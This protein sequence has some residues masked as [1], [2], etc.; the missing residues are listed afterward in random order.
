MELLNEISALAIG[1]RAQLALPTSVLSKLRIVALDYDKGSVGYYRAGVPLYYI[2]RMGLG[3]I[4]LREDIWR[5]GIGDLENIPAGFK[6]G[7]T[8]IRELPDQVNEIVTAFHNAIEW[9]NVVIVIRPWGIGHLRFIQKIKSC[10]DKLLVVDTDDHLEAVHDLGMNTMTAF[11]TKEYLEEGDPENIARFKLSLE[12]ADLITVGARKLADTYRER[13]ADKVCYLPNPVD[14]RSNRWNVKHSKFP[15]SP[16]TL[17]WIG[18]HTHKLD[19]P[20]LREPLM[21]IMDKHSE[22]RMK[23]LGYQPEWSFDLPQDRVIHQPY[24]IF[25]EL[26]KALADVDISLIPLQPHEFNMIG[27][28]DT[29]IFESAMCG[30]AVV[31]SPHGAEYDK[32]THG[33]NILFAESGEDWT[34][35]LES[36]IEDPKSIRTL[37]KNAVRF[38]LQYR[39]AEAVVP[40]WYNAYATALKSK[41]QSEPAEVAP[42]GSFSAARR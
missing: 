20:I 42:Y 38:V 4:V 10:R 12:W 40:L 39:S 26:P 13:W 5:G 31:A 34:N 33:K 7:D 8:F 16:L 19:H 15:D 9:A 35:A 14:T 36:L 11:W 3:E 28:T 6:F 1:Q 29:K 22:V 27:K 32:W 30:M 24:V 17:G 21:Q 18:G 23:F 41:I 2:K 37:N 25:E